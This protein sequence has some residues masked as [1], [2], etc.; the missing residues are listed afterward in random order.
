MKNR[1]APLLLMSLAIAVPAG[2]GD[3]DADEGGSDAP[4]AV[5]QTAEVAV[6][7]PDSDATKKPEG[8]TV[9]LKLQQLERGTLS[10][11]VPAIRGSAGLSVP[12]WMSTVNGDVASYWQSQFNRA[13]Y[14]YRVPTEYIYDR[15]GRSGCGRI[16]P[17]DGPFY[18]TADETIYLPVPFFEQQNQDFGDAA[19]ALV[20]AHE[21]AHHVQELLGIFD[22]GFLTAQTELQADCLAGIWASSVLERGLLEDGDIGEILGLTEISGDEAGTPIKDPN[23]HGTSALR[24]GFFNR[25]FEGGNPDACPVPSRAEIK[26]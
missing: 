3:D 9:L 7:E 13:G 12:D 16:G 2:C 23:A 26:G 11:E 18:C 21:N 17:D 25:G 8:E 4:V 24:A 10:S 20:I 15:R 19:V 6:D 1:L 22:Q 14:E 5:N